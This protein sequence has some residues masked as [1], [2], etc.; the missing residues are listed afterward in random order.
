MKQAKLFG[1]CIIYIFLAVSSSVVKFPT[2]PVQLK[3]K[4][5]CVHP[6][7]IPDYQEK[8]FIVLGGGEAESVLSGAGLKIKTWSSIAELHAAVNYK[9]VPTV[10]DYYILTESLKDKVY[11]DNDPVL[12]DEYNY[13]VID[14]KSFEVVYSRIISEINTYN[15]MIPMLGEF[16]AFPLN[17]L[18]F[19]KSLDDNEYNSVIERGESN[20]ILQRSLSTIDELQ[21]VPTANNKKKELN[22]HNTELYLRNINAATSSFCAGNYSLVSTYLEQ[23]EKLDPSVTLKNNPT[24]EREYVTLMKNKKAQVIQ[25]QNDSIK[26]HNKPSPI[27]AIQFNPNAEKNGYQTYQKFFYLFLSDALVSEYRVYDHLLVLE[28]LK[29]LRIP[30]KTSS[31]TNQTLRM[32]LE[33][34]LKN[35]YLTEQ[36]DWLNPDTYQQKL[37]STAFNLTISIASWDKESQSR[38]VERIVQNNQPNKEVVHYQY[39]FSAEVNV[40]VFAPT[41]NF[42]L[43]TKTFKHGT[44]KEISVG[45]ENEAFSKLPKYSNREILY[46]LFY[47]KDGVSIQQF[48]SEITK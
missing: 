34:A 43:G 21:K 41:K 5:I 33:E 47:P 18:T 7:I 37:W 10:V 23:A 12:Y 29:K 38:R 20:E 25:A 27:M 13:R 42:P 6:S 26:A 44:K 35:S 39:G 30:D 1:A 31:I 45:E 8:T 48:L 46:Q 4:K 16:K 24:L 11:Q 22:K 9:N 14:A 19:F 36:L 17:D 3:E 2:E 32:T 15:L 28:H 40:R